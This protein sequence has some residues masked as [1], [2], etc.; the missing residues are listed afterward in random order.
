VEVLL[1]KGVLPSA[2]AALLLVSLGGARLL[3]LALSIGCWVAYALINKAPAA[4]PHEL[5]RASNGTEWLLWT[6][7]VAG[8]VTALERCTVLPARAGMPV[9]VAVAAIGAWLVLDKV[10]QH[11]ATGD[12]VLHVG[13]GVGVTAALVATHR[14]VIARAPATPLPAV[15]FTVVLSVDAAIVTL[16]QSALLGQMTGAV[17]AAL[18]AAVGTTLWRRGFALRGA[19]G[20]WLGIA[21]GLSVLAAV[22]LAYL[23]WAAAGL[24][25]AAPFSLLLVPRRLAAR[26]G[27]WLALAAPLVLVPLG[28]AAWLAFGDGSSGY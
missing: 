15:L 23:P 2:A 21:H 28:V 5:W 1:L 27:R 11:W 3:P 18:G 8:I 13:L 24:A 9:G 10:A 19:D 26:P 6:T 14:V 20:T 4:W 17:A 12:A 22:H 16:G 7:I 25:L